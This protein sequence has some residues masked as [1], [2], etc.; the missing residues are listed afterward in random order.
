AIEFGRVQRIA[1]ILARDPQALERKFGE[2]VTGDQTPREWLDPAWTPVA[3]A[4]A[5]GKTEAVREF[6]AV[7]ADLDVRDSSN[8]NLTELA[9]AGGHDDIVGVLR[10]VQDAPAP[11]AE[12]R[13]APGE[14]VARFLRT[15]CLDWRTGGPQRAFAAND[16]GRMLQHHPELATTNVCTVVACGELDVARRMLDAEPELASAPGGPRSWPPLL[17]LCSARLPQPHSGENAVAIARVLLDHGADP[18]TFYLGGNADIHYTALACVLGRGEELASMHAHARALTQLL[19]ERGADPHDNQVLYNVFANNTSRHLLD[20]DIVWLL[21]LMY[22][23]SVRR[24]HLGDWTDPA[25][26]MFAMRGAPSLGDEDRFLPGA[27][28]VLDAAVDRNLVLLAEWMLAHGAGPNTPS[29]PLWKQSTRSL[30]QEALARGHS[31]MAELLVRYGATVAPLTLDEHETFVR[32][33][34]TLDQQSVRSMIRRHPELLSDARTLIA[35][36]HQDR[37]DVVDMLL[38]LG[39]SPDV[40]DPN[41]GGRALHAAA[42]AGAARSAALLIARGATVDAHDGLYDSPPLGWASHFAQ[43]PTIE[44]LGRYSS[45][46][47]RLTFAGRSDRLRELLDAE[48]ELAKATNRAGDT[49]LMWLPDDA[50]SALTIARLFLDHGANAS[51][52]NARGL[53][54]ADIATS[55][56]LEEVAALLR[57]SGG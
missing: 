35:A 45:D 40:A 7:G 8:R 14:R 24:G 2:Y 4:V 53:T 17:Y 3:Y 19:L 36:A 38:D 6:V 44:L 52:R 29:G 33:C 11:R 34:L 54:A 43:S 32:A 16:A 10:S 12:F 15:A 55:R 26:P 47:W 51:L 41:T 49:P 57:A 42:A 21:E 46:V 5:H 23:H 18:N 37:A 9:A 13:D 56:G 39:F 27:R 22:Q 50:A 30:Y 25:W 48:P 28:F 20:N 1:G 31:A